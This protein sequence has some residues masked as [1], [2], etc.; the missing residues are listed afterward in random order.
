V[1]PTIK[2]LATSV[3]SMSFMHWG[4]QHYRSLS[5]K[6]VGE[7]GGR[8]VG[9]VQRRNCDERLALISMLKY[10]P[11]Y[12]A[13][14][15]KKMRPIH[16]NSKLSSTTIPLFKTTNRPRIR[17]RSGL[18]DWQ[19]FRSFLGVTAINLAKTVGQDLS[20]PQRRFPVTPTVQ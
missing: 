6:L 11:W 2:V 16:I 15:K 9:S 12:L 5:G 17:E 14:N 8:H 1:N 20:K 7:Y 19:R 4:N 18:W 13:L 3:K 10:W